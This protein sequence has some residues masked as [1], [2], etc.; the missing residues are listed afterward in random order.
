MLVCSAPQFPHGIMDPVEEVAQ[1]RVAGS[2]LVGAF[3]GPILG[4][5]IKNHTSIPAGFEVPCTISRGRMPGW[6]PHRLHGQGKIP[7][8]SL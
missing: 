5:L 3:N 8:G 6:L 2:H 7:S 4:T 1:V